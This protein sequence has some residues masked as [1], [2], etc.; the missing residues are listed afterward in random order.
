M[1]I[2][3]VQY[4]KESLFLENVIYF[5]II[6]LPAP[7]WRLSF[8]NKMIQ[9]S[10]FIFL[11]LFP[12]WCLHKIRQRNMVNYKERI[13]LF[14]IVLLIATL[15]SFVNSLNLFHSIGDWLGLLYL[16]TLFL[17]I[18]DVINTTAKLKKLLIVF[19][20]TAVI[21]AMLGLGAFINYLITRNLNPLLFFYHV[22]SS[23]LFF[24]RI[25]SYF[26]TPNMFASFE[27]IGLATLFCMYFLIKRE[28]ASPILNSLL[29]IAVAIVT[30]S[31][32]LAGSQI[33]AGVLLTIFIIT[34]L[35]RGKVMT[36]VRY[37]VFLATFAIIIFAICATI[38]M[39]Y[40]L[41]I[42]N[43]IQQRWFNIQINTAYSHHII[44]S[45]YAVSMFRDHPLIGVGIGTFGDRYPKYINQEIE[46][47][48]SDRMKVPADRVLDPHN[49]Y[50]GALAEWGVLGFFA[51]IILFTQL[52]IM[53]YR[54]NKPG[55]NLL[56]D[57]LRFS[58]LAGFLGF[59]FNGLYIDII[60]MRHL[61]I[62]MAI[63]F[64]FSKVNNEKVTNAR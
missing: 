36:V 13:Y 2:K 20:C 44:P 14:I 34:W 23:V 43:N 24:P 15:C 46:K 7:Y 1:V 51:M 60:M 35:F 54:V 39:I 25:Q 45:I 38:W 40:P 50:T 4:F 32:F 58:L 48:S 19:S 12:V 10:D 56:S 27:H 59:L 6:M 11:I 63:I 53:L 47:I 31:I 29:I 42:D 33:L 22:E 49:T 21:A 41:K 37:I 55:N 57:G 17:I 61:W 8:L 16:T 30:V 52:I 9:T 26:H 18:T 28:K 3:I 62:F 64:I 5:Y